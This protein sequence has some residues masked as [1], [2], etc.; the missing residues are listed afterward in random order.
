VPTSRNLL[1][2]NKLR[3]FVAWSYTAGWREVSILPDQYEVLRLQR[4]DGNDV[5]LVFHKRLRTDHV[6]A[7]GKGQELVEQYFE[8]RYG[9]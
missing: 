2:F 6:T 4:Q 3:D 5:T 1:H 8:E 9:A 7:H